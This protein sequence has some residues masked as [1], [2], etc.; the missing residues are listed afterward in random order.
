[1]D[2]NYLKI[3]KLYLGTLDLNAKEFSAILEFSI[4]RGSKGGGTQNFEKLVFLN[5]KLLYGK[6]ISHDQTS[7]EYLK[8][9]FDVFFEFLI[10]RGKSLNF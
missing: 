6:E 2:P 5:F 3:T 8:T 9:I 1:M 4:L 7:L 10:L